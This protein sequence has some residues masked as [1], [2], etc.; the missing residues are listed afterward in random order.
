MSVS[1]KVIAIYSECPWDCTVVEEIINARLLDVWE[2]LSR[3]GM[4]RVSG[5][6]TARRTALAARRQA[7]ERRLKIMN[8]QAKLLD[9]VR[10]LHAS[11]SF[12]S[13][14]YGWQEQANQDTDDRNDHQQLY[15]CKTDANAC[16]ASSQPLESSFHNPIHP[17]I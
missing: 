16:M 13:S 9:V 15:Q 11:S 6:G 7:L 2:Q 8:C 3:Y 14:L 10:T 17:Q 1:L 5:R 4:N 12:A